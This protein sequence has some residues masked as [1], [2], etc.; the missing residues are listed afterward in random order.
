MRNDLKRKTGLSQHNKSTKL[1]VNFTWKIG[2]FTNQTRENHKSRRFS[3]DGDE[4]VQWQL[5]FN[6]KGHEHQKNPT[7]YYGLQFISGPIPMAAEFSLGI[8]DFASGNVLF[9]NVLNKTFTTCPNQYGFRSPQNL[10]EKYLKEDT[11][12]LQCK[13]TYQIEKMDSLNSSSVK[14]PRLDTSEGRMSHHFEQLFNT[15]RMSDIVFTLGKQ[16]IKAHKIVL[17]ARSQVFSDMFEIDGRVSPLESL[18]IED[19]E[20]E[21]FKAMLRFLYTD[22]MEETEEMAKKL[23]PIAKKYQVQ[24]LQF[25]CEDTLTKNISTENC[26]EILLLADMQDAL[27][28]KKDAL[29]YFCTH[30]GAVIKTTGWQTLRQTRPQL[31]VEIVEFSAS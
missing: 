6:A 13:L 1:K 3:A 15:G 11:L 10:I 26:A 18:K 14:V 20:P 16:K 28:L 25:K 4:K 5:I 22:E 24:L 21:V 19:C 2:N 17:S 30:S 27:L 29:A 7:I 31:A 12:T 9:E 8:I 23:L